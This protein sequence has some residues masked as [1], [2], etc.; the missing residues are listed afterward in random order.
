MRRLI[1]ALVVLGGCASE[2]I[3]SESAALWD[4]GSCSPVDARLYELAFTAL[5]GDCGDIQPI[6]IRLDGPSDTG[7]CL[8]DAEA[9]QA[10][11]SV[12]VSEACAFGDYGRTISAT[13]DAN[14]G[15]AGTATVERDGAEACAGTYEVVTTVVR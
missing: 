6:V 2:P 15:L 12:A 1:L 9:Q 14:R 4:G 10:G 8:V 7:I 13:L 11:C 5:D 3:G